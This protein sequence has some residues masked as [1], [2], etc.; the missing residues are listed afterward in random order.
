MSSVEC[1][2]SV[3]L[4]LSQ[5]LRSILSLSNQDDFHRRI[6]FY[7]LQ[8]GVHGVVKHIS[9]ELTYPSSTVEVNFVFSHVYMPPKFPLL[10]ISSRKLRSKQ[11]SNSGDFDYPS[12]FHVPNN[13]KIN[14]K[15]LAGKSIEDDVKKELLSLATKARESKK[16]G[17]RNVE[18]FL[19][20]P[21]HLIDDLED[22]L[23]GTFFFKSIYR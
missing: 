4:D 20:L 19:V 18:N 10:Q 9:N 17:G 13:F 12:Y 2:C 7:I 15:D 23:N 6:I 11:E 22:C 21:S 3:N 8:A 5:D 1:N 16:R 14:F